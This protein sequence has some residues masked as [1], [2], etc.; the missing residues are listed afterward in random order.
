MS[1]EQREIAKNLAVSGWKWSDPEA[2]YPGIERLVASIQ[3]G[4]IT[5]KAGAAAL[6]ISPKQL[7]RMFP[8][9][10]ARE[11]AAKKR[12]AMKAAT[13]DRKVAR[14]LAR[15]ARIVLASLVVS[16]CIDRG[17][18]ASRGAC[19]ERTI[20]RIVGGLQAGTIRNL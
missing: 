10:S 14:I 17:T 2:R 4:K 8:G 12:D 5:Q 15:Q 18:A 13:E 6:G 3:A 19:T 9:A 16:G 1:Q 7:R 20:A 11:E